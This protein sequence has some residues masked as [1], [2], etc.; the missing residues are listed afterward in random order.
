MRLAG[1]YGDGLITDTKSLQNVEMMA[2]FRAGA[3]AAGKDPASL[4]IIVEQWAFV[5][6]RAE[7][8]QWANLWRFIPKAFEKYVN[9]PDPR[10][11][12]AQ[13]EAELE[14]SEVSKDW[15][16]STDPAEHVEG[17]QKLIKAGASTIFVHSPQP[18]QE[19][20]IEFYGREVLPQLGRG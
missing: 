3:Q 2:A 19:R 6:E 18:D 8:D 5:G 17:L 13:A 14:L 15:A 10:S 4:P 9:N 11:I 20:M 7:V 16:V 12:Q 1:E